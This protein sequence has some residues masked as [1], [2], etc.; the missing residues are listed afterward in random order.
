MMNLGG[1]NHV[2]TAD[3]AR[4]LEQ[5]FLA[6]PYPTKQTR[7]VMAEDMGVREAQIFNWFQNRRAR[8]K[9]KGEMMAPPP[10]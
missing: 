8:G 3:Q 9:L 7:A 5:R 4:D 2:F 1:R 6:D 10:K